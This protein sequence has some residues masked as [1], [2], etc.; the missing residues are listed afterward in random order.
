MSLLCKTEQKS[1]KKC[2][3][4]IYTNLYI[5]LKFIIQVDFQY[6]KLCL[7]NNKKTFPIAKIDFHHYYSHPL[8]K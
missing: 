8:T 3:G 4:L 7:N 1:G 6:T 2:N 5:L